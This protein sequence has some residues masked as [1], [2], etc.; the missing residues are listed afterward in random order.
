MLNNLNGN[1]RRVVITGMGII[2]PVGSKLEEAW[3]NV[4]EGVSGTRLID[5]FDTSS[6]P[7]RIAGNRAAIP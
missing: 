6:Y 4:C 3:S 1:R 2:S 7:T 5:E